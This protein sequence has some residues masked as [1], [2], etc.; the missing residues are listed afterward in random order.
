M[1]GD[2]VKML[3]LFWYSLQNM[4]TE[5]GAGRGEWGFGGGGGGGGCCLA[6]M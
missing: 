2:A 5:W 3:L 1:A 4:R 6:V